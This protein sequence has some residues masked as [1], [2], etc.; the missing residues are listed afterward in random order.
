M[1]YSPKQGFSTRDPQITFVMAR[2]AST[3]PS[4]KGMD[5]FAFARDNDKVIG[6]QQ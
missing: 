5:H 4:I 2:S 1:N 6:L 3:W